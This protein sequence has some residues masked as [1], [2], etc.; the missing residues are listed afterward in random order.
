MT[1][2]FA[3]AKPLH[4]DILN[5]SD[6]AARV[7]VSVQQFFRLTARY[8]VTPVLSGA[9][10]RGPKFWHPIDVERIA[11]SHRDGEAKTA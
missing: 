5:T 6:A 11:A 1:G 9:G 2:G 8:G 3:S 4:I 7:G 10:I